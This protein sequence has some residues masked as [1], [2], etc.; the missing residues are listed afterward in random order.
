MSLK[1]EKDVSEIVANYRAKHSDL[2][3]PLLR[4]TIRLEHP[5]INTR[6]LDRHLRKAYQKRTPTKT[7]RFSFFR[8]LKERSERNERE[9]RRIERE[10]MARFYTLAETSV[11]QW[12]FMQPLKDYADTLKKNRKELD[13]E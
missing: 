8:W 3:R 12:P 13:L 6:T 2:T 5:R 11:K 9:E 10:R 7:R 1:D 4:K